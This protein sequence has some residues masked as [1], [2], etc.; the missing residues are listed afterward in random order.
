M[1]TPA[2]ARDRTLPTTTASQLGSCPVRPSKSRNRRS[3]SGCK[4]ITIS[5]RLC[6]CTGSRPPTYLRVC[7]RRNSRRQR[8][9]GSQMVIYGG[10]TK[11]CLMSRSDGFLTIHSHWRVLRVSRRLL[12]LLNAVRKRL[13]RGLTGFNSRCTQY[14]RNL[15]KSSSKKVITDPSSTDDKANR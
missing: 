12:T 6:Y 15:V 1:H 11:F 10:Y 5:P 3:S 7:N 14:L 2:P 8:L 9:H 4:K 13:R